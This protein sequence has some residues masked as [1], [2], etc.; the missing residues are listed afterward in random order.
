MVYHNVLPHEWPSDIKDIEI[1]VQMPKRFNTKHAEVTSGR[2]GK[3]NHAKLEYTFDGNTIHI[4]NTEPFERF[5]GVTIFIPLAPGYFI[6]EPEFSPYVLF[7]MI[8]AGLLTLVGLILWFTK[9]KVAKM[10]EP[11]SFYPPRDFNPAELSFY[12]NGRI[13]RNDFASLLVYFA[14]KGNIDLVVYEGHYT[15]VKKLKDL[16]ENAKEHEKVFFAKLFKESNE[17]RVSERPVEFYEILQTSLKVLGNELCNKK[18]VLP[19]KELFIAFFAL[20]TALP[21]ALLG[22]GDYNP[23]DVA[24]NYALVALPPLFIFFFVKVF[25]ITDKLRIGNIVFISVFVLPVLAIYAAAVVIVSNNL[26]HNEYLGY[27]IFICAVINII[28]GSSKFG[29]TQEGEKLYG[30][31]MG[32]RNFIE[33][34]EAD[35]LQ[36]LVDENPEYFYDILPYAYVFGLSTAWMDKLNLVQIPERE[37]FSERY[38][39]N[40]IRNNYRS[41]HA[42]SSILGTVSSI[43]GLINTTRSALAQERS[44]SRSSSSRG[45]SRGGG[46]GRSSSGGGGGG[47][48]GGSW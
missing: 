33:I 1:T 21:S 30:E 5:E 34:A 15:T 22:F 13:S 39:R 8:L 12:L 23:F 28:I 3:R 37:D 31:I 38:S 10:P 47:G 42:M 2:Y 36:A 25:R 11:V 32:F 27:F 40:E 29:R 24:V 16:D 4:K 44:A 26:Y 48:G 20:I 9:L 6:D 19:N 18:Y 45:G 14:Y 17:F 7:I 41:A 46:G 35:K 43:D